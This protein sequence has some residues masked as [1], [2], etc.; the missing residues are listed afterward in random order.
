M[1]CVLVGDEGKFVTTIEIP[2]NVNSYYCSVSLDTGELE[3]TFNP[4]NL[5]NVDE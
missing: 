1:K 5:L 3:M 4:L 2:T